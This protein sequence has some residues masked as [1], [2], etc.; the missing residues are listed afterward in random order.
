[1]RVLAVAAALALACAGGG[2]R[3]PPPPTPP[4]LL[5]AIDGL[6]WGLMKPLIDAG[7]MPAIAGLMQ[8]G[9]Y[10]YLE[11]MVPT[12]SP[13]IWTSIA[14]GKNPDK[15][16]IPHFVYRVGPGADDYRSYTSGHRKTKA[17]W[18]IL[19]EYGK[20]V[21]VIGWWM[22]YPAEAVNG[23]I[24]AQTNTTGAME[25]SEN[26]LWKGTLLEGVDDQVYPPDLT[27]EVM[28][29]LAATDRSMDSVVTAIFG[30]VPQ[31]R[32][33]FTKLVWDQSLWAFR[34]DAVYTR[35]AVRLLEDAPPP[36]VFALYLSGP[37]V[38]GHRFWRYAHPEEFW[39]P[40]MAE[41]V[42]AFGS[43]L[44]DYYV[45][46]D[47]VIGEVLSRVPADVTVFVISDHGMHVVNPDREFD[48]DDEPGF[49]LSGNHLDAPPGV[50]VAAGANI[51]RAATPPPLDPL[52]PIGR[53]YDVLPTLLALKGIP[54][55]E[56]FD[57]Q[58]MQVVISPAF[59]EQFPIR[60]VKTHDDRAWEAA[61]RDR[62]KEA[63][64]QA[65][66][67]EQLKSLGYIN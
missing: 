9:T 36:D 14:T 19:S 51:T 66:R 7:R 65:E 46:V 18:N 11:S 59:L 1:M 27:P 32:T 52:R 50:F 4:I 61:R 29:L 64:D 23:V 16:G 43:V 6:E 49:R 41:E 10:G 15:H 54:V 53:A 26:A 57:G 3:K 38:A 39:H 28:G 55:G 56:D 33:E 8:R 42:E 30:G 20:T 31:A 13:A 48:P 67:L 2:D 35:I 25:H 58:A 5:F 37:D 12:Y 62:M 24:V 47:R 60:S 34:A 44:D 17:F 63:A 40:P 45:H 22:T 21:D